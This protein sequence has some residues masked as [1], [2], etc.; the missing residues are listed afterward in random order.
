LWVLAAGLVLALIFDFLLKLARANVIDHAG[1]KLDVILSSRLFEKILS[2][3]LSHRPASTGAFANRV[4]EYEVIRE[5]FTSNTV[6][7]FVDFMF[8]FL[9][10]FI[11]MQLAGWLVIVPAVAVIPVPCRSYLAPGLVIASMLLI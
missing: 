2:T 5:F 8:V 3:K 1:R 11:I 10:L 9:F 4:A 6:A 7:L